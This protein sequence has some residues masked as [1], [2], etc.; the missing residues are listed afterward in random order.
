M[1][2]LWRGGRKACEK[3]KKRMGEEWRERGDSGVL[4]VC[5][6]KWMRLREENEYT[7]GGEVEEKQMK[8]K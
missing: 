6:K 5:C 2:E 7:C 1:G 4:I 8:K 3:E